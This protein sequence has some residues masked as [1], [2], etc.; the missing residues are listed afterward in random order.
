MPSSSSSQ[1]RVMNA[2]QDVW[3][4]TLAQIP[5][6]HG[7]LVYLSSLRS[8]DTGAYEHH[9][10]AMLFGKAEANRALAESHLRVFGEWL[11]YGLEGQKADLLLYI[12]DLPADRRTVIETWLRLA[13]YRNLIPSTVFQAQRE[14]YL[15]DMQVLLEQLKREWGADAEDQGA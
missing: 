6:L 12:S 10:L 9:G 7:R 3:R 14:L 1:M 13:P 8:G 11:E 5:T 15:A 4:R 2:S